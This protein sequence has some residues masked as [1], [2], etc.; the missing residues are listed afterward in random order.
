MTSWSIAQAEWC[1]ADNPVVGADMGQCSACGGDVVHVGSFTAPAGPLAGADVEVGF[2]LA[3]GE[4]LRLV[5]SAG[6]RRVA[7]PEPA[8]IPPPT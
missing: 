8:L 1:R 3:C 4:A 2:C 7:A 5:Q 6:V